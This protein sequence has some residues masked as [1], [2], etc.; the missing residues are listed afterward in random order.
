[1]EG[2]RQR[3][4]ETTSSLSADR[5][6]D[7]DVARQRDQGGFGALGGHGGEGAGQ[8]REGQGEVLADIARMK[9]GLLRT[10]IA[11]YDLVRQSGFMDERFPRYDGLL[12]SIKL[13]SMTSFA[14]L[15]EPLVNKRVHPGS[16]STS[17]TVFDNLQEQLGIFRDIQPLL[18][19]R[20][21][22]ATVKSVNER[23]KHRLIKQLNK[24]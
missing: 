9:F 7:G 10:L 14:Y 21:D 23:W 18:A 24:L 4:Q 1:M 2:W 3:W 11:D 13:A 19:S 8:G 5:L 17:N 12:L 15:H 22:E 20:L 6:G 16:D